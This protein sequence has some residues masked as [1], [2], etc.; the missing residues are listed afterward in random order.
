[1]LCHCEVYSVLLLACK[2]KYLAAKLVEFP[3]AQ[4]R[5]V[6]SKQA[7]PGT[8]QRKLSNSAVEEKISLLVT[9]MLHSGLIVILNSRRYF[10]NTN[11][12]L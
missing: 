7:T 3:Y 12:D 8:F 6:K 4:E 2:L 10:P 9:E 5:L 1:M 11:T